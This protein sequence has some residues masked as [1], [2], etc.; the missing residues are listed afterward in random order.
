[1]N[2]PE[3]GTFMDSVDR[4]I[5]PDCFKFFNQTNFILN[6]VFINEFI[7]VFEK[8][9]IESLGNFISTFF[10]IE[11]DVS[12]PVTVF[13]QDLFLSSIEDEYCDFIQR[14]T[15]SKMFLEFKKKLIKKFG[16]NLNPTTIQFLRNRLSIIRVTENIKKQRRMSHSCVKNES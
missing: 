1:M 4:F 8:P 10:E 6:P 5:Y 16:N 12:Q 3:H 15:H 14:V 13:N 11:T 9:F 2:S 7:N